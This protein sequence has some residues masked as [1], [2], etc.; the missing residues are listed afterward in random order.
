[1][2]NS[3]HRALLLAVAAAVSAAGAGPVAEAQAARALPS[4]GCVNDLPPK[5][6]PRPVGPEDLL[7]KLPEEIRFD[8]PYPRLLPVPEPAPRKKPVRI[9]SQQ[10]PE[11]KKR[12]VDPCPDITDPR[13]PKPSGG[14]GSL[15]SLSLAFPKITFR[16]KPINIPYAVP[17]PN[18]PKIPP[19]PAKVNPGWDVAPLA[20]APRPPRVRSVRWVS[21]LT[22]KG[23]TSRTDKR[24]QVMGTDLGIMWESKPGKIAIAF[25]DTFG[26]GFKPPGANGGD[27]RSNIVG[28]SSDK[29]LSDGM[30]IDTMVQDSRCH[31]VQVVDSR[32]INYYEMTTIPTSGFALGDRQYMTYM[33]VRTWGNIPGTWLTNYGGLAYSDDEGS[34]WTRDPHLRWDNVFGV[35]QF[36]VSSMVPQGDYVYMFGTPNSRLG[37]VGLARVRKD[38]VLNR[39]AYQYWRDGRW[40]PSRDPNAAS[41]L[42]GGP[43]GELSVRYNADAERWEMTYLDTV[44]GAIV[45]RTARKPQGA[46]SAPVQ[47]VNS[48]QRTQLY[49]GFI[50]PWSTGND[51]YFTLSQWSTYNVNLMRARV[52]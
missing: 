43:T 45:M 52:Y 15:G 42:F 41:V 23:S 34:T 4:S 10:P 28:F 26:K 14:T 24:W 46:W 9:P 50:H 5:P 33:S 3:R 44:A 21:T 38:D 32:H 13:K 49:G 12:C 20:A 35:S 40:I 31:A 17:N 25:G 51:L 30:S 39:T 1:M 8:L 16:P 29:K 36:Q 11:K 6:K 37:S 2:G 7:P 47:L 48:G 27:W 19:P 18:P 22:G